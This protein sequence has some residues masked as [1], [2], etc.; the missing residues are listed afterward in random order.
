MEIDSTLSPKAKAQLKCEIIF[1]THNT[2]LHEI[3]MEWHPKGEDFLWKPELQET[4]FSQT[5]GKNLRYKRGFKAELVKTFLSLLEE[6]M[7]Y[8]KVRYAF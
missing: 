8:C 7:P 5:G 1:L 3:N 4:K 6:M 2:L